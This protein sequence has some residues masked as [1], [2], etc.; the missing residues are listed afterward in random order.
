MNSTA[1]L[2]NNLDTTVRVIIDGQASGPAFTLNRG[3]QQ[4]FDL[5]KPQTVI[6]INCGSLDTVKGAKIEFEHRVALSECITEIN[7]QNELTLSLSITGVSED[8]VK[9]HVV[10]HICKP[11]DICVP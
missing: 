11:T 2:K 7:E 1:I 5:L 4:Q 10:G 8:P 6:Q 3:E 9:H